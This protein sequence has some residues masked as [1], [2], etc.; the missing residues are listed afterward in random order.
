MFWKLMIDIG[1]TAVALPLAA[2]IAAWLIT[3]RAWKMA[4]Y[5]CLMLVAGLSLVALSKIA[6]LGWDAG[7]QS[8]D[9]KALSGHALC[10][11]AVVPVLFFVVLQSAPAG[12]RRAGVLFGL[13]V[14]AGLGLLLVHFEYHTAS[15]VIAS[16]ILGSVISLGYIRIAMTSPAPRVTWWTVPLC[17]GAF[18]LIF[19]LKPSS[20]NHRLV[21]VALYL[22]GR[23]E[24]YQWTGKLICEARVPLKR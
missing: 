17:I 24:P 20:I 23:D 14:S 19:I 13:W 2:A 18:A 10:A 3:G 15:E 8:I 12:W 9:F 1:H 21:D 7:I 22:S 11:T 5:W 4:L 16:F 6:F